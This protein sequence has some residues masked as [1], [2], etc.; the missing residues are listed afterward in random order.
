[1]TRSLPTLRMTTRERLRNADTDAE[2]VKREEKAKLEQYVAQHRHIQVFG[3]VTSN[4][5]PAD[6]A[7]RCRNQDRLGLTACYPKLSI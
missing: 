5:L 6:R 2:P 4:T 1:M 7:A 3:Y